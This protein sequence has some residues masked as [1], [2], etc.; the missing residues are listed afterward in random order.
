MEGQLSDSR[1]MGLSLLLVLF[2][3][4]PI[5]VLSVMAYGAYRLSLVR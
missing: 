2:V 4:A 3:F 1:R 5:A